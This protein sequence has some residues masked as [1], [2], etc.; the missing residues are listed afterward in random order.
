MQE[1]RTPPSEVHTKCRRRVEIGVS[2][3]NPQG[4]IDGSYTRSRKR[5]SKVSELENISNQTHDYIDQY[6]ACDNM[7]EIGGQKINETNAELK[8]HLEPSVKIESKESPE[9]IMPSLD[10]DHTELLDNK[11]RTRSGSPSSTHSDSHLNNRLEDS[12]KGSSEHKVSEDFHTPFHPSSDTFQY[13]SQWPHRLESLMHECE[14]VIQQ[15]QH[16]S[17]ENERLL[18]DELHKVQVES[19]DILNST[20]AQQLETAARLQEEIQVHFDHDHE[21]N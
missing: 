3:A 10:T 5:Y 15:E 17:C 11:D 6:N 8:V 7:S 19:G 13:Q 16:S 1:S 9:T 12:R 4:M 2:P 21:V 18:Q 20:K 14:R